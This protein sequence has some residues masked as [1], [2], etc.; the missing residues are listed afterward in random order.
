MK[1]FTSSVTESALDKSNEIT[2]T[3]LEM[4]ALY[5]MIDAT[6]TSKEM[7][8]TKHKLETSLKSHITYIL[9]ECKDLGEYYHYDSFKPIDYN[10][11]FKD[12]PKEDAD[13]LLDIIISEIHFR[14]KTNKEH[15]RY[16]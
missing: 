15:K 16:I 3:P 8:K 9:R 5:M 7:Q 10:E 13:N 6:D 12:L 1:N 11:I 14:N 2:L 4:F